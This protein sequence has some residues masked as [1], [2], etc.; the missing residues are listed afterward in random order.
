MKVFRF[1]PVAIALALGISSCGDENSLIGSSIV[2]TDLEIVVDSSFQKMITAESIPNDSVVG[3]TITQLIGRISIP[4]Y[5][6]LETDF[7]TQFMSASTFDTVGVDRLDS[8]VLYLSYNTESFT[9]DSLAPMQLSVYPLE[10]Q[11]QSP[12]YSSIDPAD[13]Y[14]AQSAP[15]ALKS[16][17]ASFLGLPDSLVKLGY[18][19]IRVKLP[20]AMAEQFFEK[21]KTDPLIFSSPSRFT[22][23]FPGFYVKT[24]YGSGCVVNVQNSVMNLHYTKT[25]VINDKDSTY[26]STQTLM[27]VTPEIA[28]GNH[29]KLEIDPAIESGI[30]A[31]RVYLVA[32]AGLNVLLH[33]PTRE[34]VRSFEES[35]GAGGSTIQGLINS[36]ILEVPLKELPKSSYKLEPPQ[37]LLFVRKSELQK[38][39]EKKE[40]ADNVRSFYAEYNS[41]TR[42]YSFT[43]LRT[44]LNDVI[45]KKR[46]GTEITDADEEIV[47]VPVSVYSETVSSGSSYYYYSYNEQE[48]VTDIVP[49]ISAPAL[50]EIDMNNIRLQLTYSRQKTK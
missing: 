38:F 22:Q 19:T 21:Y 23:Y 30:A 2:D 45:E 9:G 24:S 34:I 11:L 46:Q 48:V 5:G 32:P 44:F 29:I 41:D 39:F 26:A 43:G 3:R 35:V 15:I 50:A 18:K 28:T 27:A 16:Y 20:D 6:K 7:L 37:F 4:G 31:G 47:L 1:L 49:Y 40:L 10:K 12:V 14:N 36:L 33:F 25:T 42:K 13:Y 8:L 17:N